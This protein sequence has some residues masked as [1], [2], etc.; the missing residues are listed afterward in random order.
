MVVLSGVACV[1]RGGFI[2]GTVDTAWPS[3]DLLHCIAVRCVRGAYSGLCFAGLVLAI[4]ANGITNWSH[5]SI[6]VSC[7]PFTLLA[8]HLVLK[9]GG[10][11]PTLTCV[12]P[13]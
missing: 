8:P 1:V 11:G 3:S 6:P 9:L 13:C 5:Q 10:V 4:V 2:L 12:Q 7:G